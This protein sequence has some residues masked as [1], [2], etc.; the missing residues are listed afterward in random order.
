[1]PQP[2]T[3]AEKDPEPKKCVIRYTSF[4]S[5]TSMCL[6]THGPPLDVLRRPAYAFANNPKA[7]GAVQE[8]KSKWWLCVVEGHLLFYQY[9]GDTR[10]RFIASIADATAIASRE[11]QNSVVLLFGDRRKWVFDFDDVGQA[12][13]FVFTVTET[14]KAM[15]GTSYYFKKM[16]ATSLRLY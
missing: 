7:A 2:S 3:I 14:R 12:N 15:E 4:S 16:K 5:I 11:Q 1:M 9:Y 6:E 10:P 8:R 13:R